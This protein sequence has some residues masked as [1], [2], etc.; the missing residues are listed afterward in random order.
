[1]I[2]Y[3]ISLIRNILMDTPGMDNWDETFSKHEIVE[4]YPEE[5][6]I[7]KVV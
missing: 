4:E 2:P 1:M 3:P 7:K 5:N 6:G